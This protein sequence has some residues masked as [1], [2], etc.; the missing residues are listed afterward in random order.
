MVLETFK[1]SD[2]ASAEFAQKWLA[3][4]K[5]IRTSVESR[6]EHVVLVSDESFDFGKPGDE[7]KAKQYLENIKSLGKTIGKEMARAGLHNYVFS[8]PALRTDK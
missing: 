4:N 8:S 5:K 3:S 7:Q 1:A 2:K 6:G